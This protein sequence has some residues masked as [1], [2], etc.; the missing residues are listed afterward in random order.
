MMRK[1]LT[2]ALL[3]L[4]LLSRA[5]ATTW[6]LNS[7]GD[8]VSWSVAI[9]VVKVKSIER[10]EKV[11]R[12]VASHELADVVVEVRQSLKGTLPAEIRILKL[13]LGEKSLNAS[14]FPPLPE[15]LVGLELLVFLTHA[16]GQKAAYRAN[17]RGWIE[18]GVVQGMAFSGL[19]QKP[20]EDMRAI[21]SELAAIQKDCPGE[22][23]LVKDEAVAIAACR[24]AVRSKYP[25]V[26]WYGARRL[27][28]HR[29]PAELVA[30]LLP[31]AQREKSSHPVR[32]LVVRCLGKAGD[33][34]AVPV[35]IEILRTDP[36]DTYVVD[37]LEELS[38]QKHGADI[39]RWEAWWKQQSGMK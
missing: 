2:A 6:G 36:K 12:R 3:A 18:K 27:L 34:K 17:N 26:I 16:E 9:A 33:K 39:A 30:D 29:V 15:K 7:L 24:S 20:L 37:A 11:A 19:R 10:V 21:V 31:I 14:P 35:L 8:T 1:Q 25:E 5:Q 28:D 22:R 13:D 4:L 38:G 32:Y 23:Y